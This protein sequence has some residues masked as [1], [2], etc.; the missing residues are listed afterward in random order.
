VKLVNATVLFSSFAN[1]TDILLGW[2]PY[3]Y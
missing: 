2:Q 1:P 3:A